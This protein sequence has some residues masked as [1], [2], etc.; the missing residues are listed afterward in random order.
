MDAGSRGRARLVIVRLAKKHAY[1]ETDVS[2]TCLNLAQRGHPRLTY[3]HHVGVFLVGKG[4]G[5]RK[6]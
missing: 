2:E 5:L 1:Q 3:P 6:E 4:K